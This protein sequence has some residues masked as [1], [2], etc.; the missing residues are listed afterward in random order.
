[1]SRGGGGHLAACARCT[2]GY[3]GGLLLDPDRLPYLLLAYP[4]D[5]HS[6][7]FDFWLLNMK[8]SDT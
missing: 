1:M 2:D 4:N 5:Y 7:N 6:L 8:N 3:P